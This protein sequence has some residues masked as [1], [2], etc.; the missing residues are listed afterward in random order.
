MNRVTG[1]KRLTALLSAGLLTAPLLLAP[2]ASAA[3]AAEATRRPTQER[4]VPGTKLRA[5]SPP[6]DPA[7][8]A[9]RGNAPAVTWPVPGTATVDLGSQRAGTVR[10]GSLPLWLSRGRGDGAVPP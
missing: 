10:A 6:A 4:S 1:P 2:A 5:T 3:P 8:R 7:E 9:A